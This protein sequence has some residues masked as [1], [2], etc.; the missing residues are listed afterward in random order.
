MA[1]DAVAG[2][3]RADRRVERPVAPGDAGLLVACGAVHL[4]NGRAGGERGAVIHRLQVR[5]A[6][7][8]DVHRLHRHVAIRAR[9]RRL[10][11]RCHS[12]ARGRGVVVQRGVEPALEERGNRSVRVGVAMPAGRRIRRGGWTWIHLR[13][14]SSRRRAARNGVQHLVIERRDGRAH[15]QH[16]AAARAVELD[17]GHLDVL[18]RRSDQLVGRIRHAA[19]PIAAGDGKEGHVDRAADRRLVAAV[20]VTGSAGGVIEGAR[21]LRG[22]HVVQ[23]GPLRGVAGAPSSPRRTIHR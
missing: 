19:A 6:L 14:H 10:R 17:L 13:R 3:G 15:P 7:L 1:D 9:R 20:A 18:I 4:R 16:Q 11:Q 21:Q 22:W 2:S 8:D 5:A 23:V 12:T